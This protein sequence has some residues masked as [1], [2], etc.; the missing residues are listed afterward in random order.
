MQ[1]RLADRRMPVG[2]NAVERRRVAVELGIL[3]R[4]RQQVEIADVVHEAREQ[5]FLRIEPRRFLCNDERQ[6]GNLQAVAPC[7]FGALLV[8]LHVVGRAQLVDRNGDGDRANRFE[9]D[10]RHRSANVGHRLAAGIHGGR[11]RD[12]NE[13][14]G[15][16]RLGRN[17]AR[18]ALGV[19]CR[20][21]QRAA[22]LQCRVG[23]RRERHLAPGQIARD[24]LQEA[25]RDL[26]VIRHGPGQ[27]EFVRSLAR[28]RCVGQCRHACA[29]CYSPTASSVPCSRA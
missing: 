17:D 25:E 3:R 18:H 9:A 22:N 13:L 2:E 27:C 10:A 4:L 19:D 20:I 12:L 7:D 24:V 5:R 14:G 6:R 28:R 21:L 15:E 16:Q 23:E 1:H 26:L 11:V 8:L 29:S